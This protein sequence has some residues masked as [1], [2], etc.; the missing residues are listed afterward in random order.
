MTFD[1]SGR[2]KA[3][4]VE[5]SLL[6][7]ATVILRKDLPIREF[8]E[9]QRV[10]AGLGEGEADS[11]AYRDSLLEFYRVFGDTVL[12]QWDL[13]DGETPIVANGEGMTRIGMRA[14]GEIIA[15]FNATTDVSPNSSAG[16][17]NGVSEPAAP[18]TMG[19]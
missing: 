4:F 6:F 12:V 3:E 14:A 9:I 7:G 11:E 1:V 17:P 15:A 13:A 5:G 19:R 10:S 16:S 18:E 2:V 8:L